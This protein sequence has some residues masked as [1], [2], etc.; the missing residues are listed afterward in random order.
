MP[1]DTSPTFP[2]DQHALGFNELYNMAKWVLKK[3]R[4]GFSPIGQIDDPIVG[5]SL[6]DVLTISLRANHGRIRLA[7]WIGQAQPLACCFARHIE[8]AAFRDSLKRRAHILCKWF[9]LGQVNAN[10]GGQIGMNG[11]DLHAIQ[12]TVAVD[13]EKRSKT[14][15]RN[16]HRRAFVDPV[17]A[18]PRFENAHCVADAFEHLAVGTATDGVGGNEADDL[19]LPGGDLRDLFRTSR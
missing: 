10:S 16:S 6:S 7:V 5:A 4:I 18:A 8:S 14:N 1:P 15:Q 17:L 13:P 9:G 12:P 2:G 11:G 3:R 19:R